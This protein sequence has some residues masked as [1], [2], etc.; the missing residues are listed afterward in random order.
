MNSD[1]LQKEI[2]IERSAIRTDGYLISIGELAS[3]YRGGEIK[4]DP[5]FQRYFR[6][7]QDRKTR[8][9]ESIILGIPIPSFFVSQRT[10]GV[11]ELVDGLQRLST[12]FEL[13]G[14]LKD[15]DGRIKPELRLV[16]T[17]YLP[18]LE[19]MQW[20]SGPDGF[21]FDTAQKLFIK[22]S[23]FDVKIVLKESDQ[24]AKFEL[25][26][27]LNTGGASLSEQEVRNAMLVAG[28]PEF[29]QWLKQLASLDAFV[30]STRLSER[31]I[32]EQFDL[33][34]VLR[35]LAFRTLGD[36][37]LKRIGD[38]GEFLTKTMMEMVEKFEAMQAAET[39][40]FQ[41]TFEFVKDRL[42]SDA[43]RKFDT[44]KGRFVGGFSISA[45]E[46]VALG[47]GY[48]IASLG[49]IDKE[50]LLKSVRSV[51]IDPEFVSSSGSGVR[52]STR[53]P[54]TVSLGRGAFKS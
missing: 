40:A 1:A 52:A 43:F 32:E 13:M 34:L 37:E 19:G 31:L 29:L 39:H 2:D 21:N 35:F 4:I 23:K 10:D 9:I 5:D 47:L 20:D 17:N 11:W 26:Q 46:V 12:V 30:D 28:K 41:A 45:F 33:E 16:G 51:W 18:S 7:D 50:F 48:N 22:R 27:R 38:L 25:F 42:G 53:I 54:K 3:M 6:W 36:E 24:K 8:F 44:D 15:S 49:K 14:I